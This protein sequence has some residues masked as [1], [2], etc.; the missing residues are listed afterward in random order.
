MLLSRFHA[1]STRHAKAKA[2]QVKQVKPGLARPSQPSK[3]CSASHLAG[4]KSSQA[5]SK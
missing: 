3:S 1:N 5:K 2:K 4:Q